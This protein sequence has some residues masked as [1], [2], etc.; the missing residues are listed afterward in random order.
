MDKEIRLGLI[1]KIK[2]KLIDLLTIAGSTIEV[3]SERYANCLSFMAKFLCSM[4]YPGL[5]LTVK[6]RFKICGLNKR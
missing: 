4:I 2:L 5:V 1:K 6:S 3:N